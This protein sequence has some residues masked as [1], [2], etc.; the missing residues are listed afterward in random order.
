[1]KNIIYILFPF[2]PISKRIIESFK[3]YF[4]RHQMRYWDMRWIVEDKNSHIYNLNGKIWTD[5]FCEC[6]KCGVK[7]KKIYLPKRWGKWKKSDFTPNKT[8]I[9]E[10]EVIQYG[11]ESKRQKRDKL[12]N[13]LLN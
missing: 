1:M 9:I 3:P 5:S 7:Y 2:I 13:D 6:Q 11:S 12:I 10:V 4:C 8:N